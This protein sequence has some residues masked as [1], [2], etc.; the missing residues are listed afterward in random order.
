MKPTTMTDA[1]GRIK[2]P[3]GARRNLSLAGK[4]EFCASLS[5][6]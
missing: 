3:L 2:I 4:T 6:S 5:Q 1:Q